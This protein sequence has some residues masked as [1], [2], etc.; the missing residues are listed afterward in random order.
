VVFI[1]IGLLLSGFAVLAAPLSATAG[2]I[3]AL[4]IE[5]C[6]GVLG[7]LAFSQGIRSLVRPR[8]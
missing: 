7:V 2:D 3:V 8:K 5:G 4:A 1:L 6:L